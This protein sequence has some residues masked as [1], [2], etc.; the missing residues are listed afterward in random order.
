MAALSAVVLTVSVSLVGASTTH[1]DTAPADPSDPASPVTVSA[2]EL[3][4]PQINGVVWSMAMVGDIVYVGGSFSNARPA[5]SPAGQNTVPRANMMAF[6]VTTGQM[7]SFA[8]TFNQQ[9]RSI[10]VSPDR[11]RIY[12]GGEFTT[13]NGQTRQRIAAF[14][15]NTGALVPNFAPSVNYHVRAVVATNSKVFV[16]GNFSGVGNADRRN[17]AAFNASNGALLD[18]APQA[19]GGIVD[20]I[21]VNPQ[22]TK[23]AVGGG[24]T[25]LNGSSNPGYGLGMVDAVTGASLPFETNQWVRN[26]TVDGAIDTLATDGTYIYGG[27]WTFGRSGGTWEGVF[28]ASWDDGKVHWLNDCHGDMYGVFPIG[29]VIYGAGHTHYCENIDGVRQ[30]AGGVGDYPYYRGVAFGRDVTGTASW[31]PDQRRYYSF[32]GQPTSE[33]LAWFPNLNAGTYTGQFQ[34]PWSVVG[35]SDY[36]VMGGE[37]T[38]VNGTS[39][40]GLTRFTV[41]SRAPNDEGPTLF[42]A[43]YPLNVSSTETG[44]VRINWR[45]NQDIDNENLTYRVYRDNQNGSGLVHTRT[46]EARFWNPYTMGFTDTGLAPGSTHRYRVAVT[47]PFGNIANSPW[48]NVTVASSGTNSDYVEAVYDDEP[49]DYWRMGEASGSTVADAVG[50]HPLTTSAGVTLGAGGAIGGDDDTAV[51]FS[52]DTTGMAVTTTPGNPP[53]VF[54]VE[55]WFKTTTTAGGRIVGWSNRNTDRTSS[56]HDRQLYM[57]TS[58]RVHF[59]VKPNADRVVVTSP[60]TYNDGD[61]HHAVATLSGGGMTLYLDGERVGARSDV[62]VGEHLSIGY[63]RIGTDTLSGWPSAP[64]GGSF[65][66]DIDEVAIYK[67]ALSGAR[68]AA[69]YAAATGAEPPNAAPVA[70]FDVATD[71]LGVSVD[72]SDS[73]DAD[74]TIASYAWTFGDGGTATGATASHTY[75]APGTYDVTLTVTDNDGASRSLT[76]EVT[77]AAAD[78][79]P[80][81]AFTTAVTGT[82]LAVDGRGSTDDGTIA[83]YGWEFG[84]GGT[85]TGATASHTYGSGGTFDVTLTV[86]DDNGQTDELTQQVT[87]AAANVAPTASFTTSPNGLTVGV[88]GTGSEDPDGTIASY[89]WTFGDGATATGATASH[90]YATAGTYDVTLTVTDDDGATKSLTQ[91]V[92]VSA[93]ATPLALDAFTRSV[94]NGWGSA[95]LGGI[96]TRSG[97]SSNFSVAGGTGLIRMGSPGAGPGMVLGGISSTDTDM[98]VRVG[99]DKAPTGGGTYLTVTPR[100]LPSGD[101]YFLDTRQT[102]TGQVIATLGRRVANSES[103]LQSRT[104]PGV[105]ATAGQLLEVRVQAFGTSPT[106]VRAK[107]WTTGTPEPDAWTVSAT[108]STAG[109]QDAGGVALRAYL[110]GSATSA[111]VMGL[112]DDLWVGP[113]P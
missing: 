10:S 3:P 15:A 83:S 24:F 61:W 8:P 69:H 53:D 27:G 110:S 99:A 19:T 106:T 103:Y 16:G 37:F 21:T 91:E 72:G 5:G 35:N 100:Y 57:D 66:G 25:A 45:T 86:T 40:Q 30:G 78:A 113:T 12:V 18:W 112:F 22:G 111:P 47:D 107:V 68:V 7:T 32:E 1:A 108:D 26:G 50:F 9:V 87:I 38:R 4:T 36:V 20:A 77:V 54:T 63:W 43:T 64:A 42:N 88:D 73:S 97:S 31:E 67:T 90:T 39:Q 75:A 11:S 71:A 85:A 94:S 46:A 93:E 109:L 102:S 96:W 104:V 29:D 60:G 55:T 92:T 23:V 95:D 59:G 44:Q 2:D 13:V 48:T 58:G 89:A 70:A 33:H 28:A 82:T 34:G 101:R 17:L 51:T 41:S 56:K 84:D 81:A 74:G 79:P 52:G 105:T 65:A 14:D 6:N 80:V 76:K 49:T 98:K 62:T